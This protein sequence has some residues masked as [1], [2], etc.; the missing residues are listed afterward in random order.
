MLFK[1]FQVFRLDDG[2]IKLN[3]CLCSSLDGGLFHMHADTLRI[4]M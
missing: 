4:K 1:R 2:V 3:T